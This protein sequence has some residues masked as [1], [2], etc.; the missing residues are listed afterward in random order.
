MRNYLV[1]LKQQL[2]IFGPLRRV[3]KRILEDSFDVAIKKSDHTQSLM[4]PK[5]QHLEY[6][7]TCRS[8]IFLYHL[9][10]TIYLSDTNYFFSIGS[11]IRLTYFTK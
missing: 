7:H 10:R 6:F 9:S 8:V 11:L 5:H 4:H 2:S 1:L 3:E